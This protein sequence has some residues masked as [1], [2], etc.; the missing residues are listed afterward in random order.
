MSGGTSFDDFSAKTTSSLISYFGRDI[1]GGGADFGASERL[2]RPGE[3]GEGVVLHA[4]S[5]MPSRQ[6]RGVFFIFQ[7]LQ[8]SYITEMNL[9]MLMQYY[10]SIASPILTC[11][12]EISCFLSGCLHR[13]K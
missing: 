3:S 7:G 5:R 10:L 9:S 4:A 6:T 1:G 13:E 12:L 11:F 2:I 8:K